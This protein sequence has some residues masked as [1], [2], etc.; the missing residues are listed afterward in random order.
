MSSNYRVSLIASLVVILG[1]LGGAQQ[2]QPLLQITSPANG[3][4]VGPG[5][6]VS[7]VVSSPAGVSF[8]SV[9]LRGE[10]PI[11]FSDAA[12]ALPATFS[13]TIPAEI[14]CRPYSLRA[15]GITVAGNAADSDFIDLDVER[16]DMPIS[17]SSQF[18]GLTMEAQGQLSPMMLSATFSDGSTLQVT[19]STK[20][21]YQSTNTSVFTV[22]GTGTATAVAPGS[23]S[24]VATYQNSNGP[25]LQI[26]IPVTV[27]PFALTFSPPSLDF[28]N[29]LVGSSASISITSTNSLSAGT[30]NIISVATGAPYAETDNCMSSSPLAAGATCTINVTFTPPAPGQASGALSIPNSSSAVESVVLLNGVGVI[31]PPNIT[32]ISP[33]VTGPVGTPITITGTH[34]GPIQG[35]STVVI[36]GI[37]ATPTSWSDTSIALNVPNVLPVGIF[38]VTVTA[39][40]LTS[41][42]K[43]FNVAPGVNSFSP[44]FGPVG[45]PITISGTSFGA[46]QGSSFVWVCG[47]PPDTITS[48]SDTAIVFPMP[49][50]PNG[51]CAIS[52]TVN[53]IG[54]VTS[55]GYFDLSPPAITSL[56]QTYGEVGLFLGIS[57]SNFGLGYTPGTVT[58]N[59]L[60]ATVESWTPSGVSVFVP[61]GATSG[62]VVVTSSHGVSS[63][64]I[65]FTVI[66]PRSFVMNPNASTTPGLLQLSVTAHGTTTF[67]S[68]D[69]INQP[70]G[71]YLIEAFDTQSGVPNSSS[72]WPAS[73]PAGV[74]VTM[75]Q[76]AGTAGT[77]FPEMKLFLNGPSGTPIC[78][79]IGTSAL[80][81]TQT[82]YNL[83]CTS[84]SDITL[85]PADRY[86]LWVGVNST[87]AS[88]TSLQF[89]LFLG[90]AL[91]SSPDYG[92]LW[93]PIQ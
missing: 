91:R 24:L 53:G 33:I 60:P 55:P 16:A 83:N 49:N 30:L 63:N 52:V 64:G 90:T 40:G 3:A 10:D 37:T 42:T 76:I 43:N 87:A 74:T 23:A 82:K 62:N 78:S 51:S 61:S 17:L 44:A 15:L 9:L 84:S 41:N 57:G 29:V 73:I 19:E 47:A 54:S 6:T 7:V 56:S 25:N 45:T 71:E 13:I 34:F 80:S 18:P 21:T 66:T 75:Q 72:T 67:V 1:T 46:T 32:D 5:Q 28:G 8:S 2:N 11:G 58:I 70:T 92:I 86:Y 89:E 93:V 69:L 35:N 14:D 39:N 36:G 20:V 81:S 88:S 12:S 22:D 31:P 50:S 59:G 77:L 79:S 65:S 4:V 48:W 38:D 85:A 68:Q 26:S 27:L